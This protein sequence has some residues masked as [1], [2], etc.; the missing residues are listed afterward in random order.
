MPKIDM[1]IL[2]EQGVFGVDPETGEVSQLRSYLT[3][4]GRAE[5]ND[6][7]P[8]EAPVGMTRN[9]Q[10]SLADLVRMYVQL[11]S[12]A[13]EENE[14]E[15]FE[16]A[17][18]FDTGDGEPVDKFT[19]WDKTFDRLSEAEKYFGEQRRKA[20]PQGAVPAQGG[21]GGAATPPP[22]PNQEAKPTDAKP[23]S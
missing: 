20:A 2:I 8:M 11:G 3:P 4:D 10:P 16:E 14:L 18:D 23:T 17:D 21:E 9:P 6:P 22:S 12:R 19:E 13:A 15:T 7:L 1:D 5:I